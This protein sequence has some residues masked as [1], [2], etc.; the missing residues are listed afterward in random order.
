MPDGVCGFSAT[1]LE[2]MQPDGRSAA[3]IG[4]GGRAIGVPY[5]G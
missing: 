2:K 5:G 4:C 3:F 1:V